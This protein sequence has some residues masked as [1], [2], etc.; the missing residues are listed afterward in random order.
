MAGALGAGLGLLLGGAMGYERQKRQNEWLQENRE[1]QFQAQMLKEHPEAITIPSVQQNVKKLF[2]QPSVDILQKA[3]ET[4]QGQSKEG[5]KIFSGTPG[6]QAAPGTQAAPAA[7]PSPAGQMIA[8]SAPAA[9]PTGLPEGMTREKFQA[10]SEEDKMAYV[11]R[12]SAAGPTEAMRG[13]APAAGPTAAPAATGGRLDPETAPLPALKEWIDDANR[14]LGDRSLSGHI[15]A[16]Q[17]RRWDKQLDE[18]Q[19]IYDKRSGEERA[20]ARKPGEAAATATAVAKALQPIRLET[21]AKLTALHNEE[22]AKKP[23]HLNFVNEQRPNK[24]TGLTEVFRVGFDPITGKEK[25]RERLGIS[26]TNQQKQQISDAGELL[27]AIPDA[28]D[29]ISKV[30][31]KMA[32]LSDE[33]KRY[34]L[35]REYVR[36][37]AARSSAALSPI[38]PRRVAYAAFSAPDPDFAQYFTMMGQIQQQATAGMHIFRAM[39]LFERISPHVPE[40][41][42]LPTLNK[43]RLKQLESRFGEVMKRASESTEEG[44]ISPAPA[45]PGLPPPPPDAEGGFVD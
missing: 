9:A 18:Y 5:Q 24:K 31:A 12:A 26:L 15:P 40:P 38:D 8:P 36:Y 44:P 23:Q 39:G 20:S 22:A 14:F 11:K 1:A 2:G 6:Q 29:A 7:P 27:H 37:N 45:E 30:E 35:Q 28:Y 3:W 41:S 16:E 21:A 10:L 43:D 25:S 34:H 33:E 13:G 19:K 32:G 4:Y 42:D 17:K